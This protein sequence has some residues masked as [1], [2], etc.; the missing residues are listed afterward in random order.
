MSDVTVKH[1]LYAAILL[2]LVAAAITAPHA[3]G[4]RFCPN[5]R[6]LVINV[7]DRG[8]RGDGVAKDAPAIVAAIAEVANAGGGTVFF[9]GGTYLLGSTIQL[10]PE[11][12]NLTL[13]GEGQGRTLIRDHTRLGTHRL[14]HITA[15]PASRVTNLRLRWIS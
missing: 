8:A 5:G 13:C 2:L 3:E 11:N 1:R 15:T 12:S 9:P 10:Y 6:G 7:K 4:T 14:I